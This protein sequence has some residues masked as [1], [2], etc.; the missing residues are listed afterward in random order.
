MTLFVAAPTIIFAIAAESALYVATETNIIESHKS[1]AVSVVNLATK[2]LANPVYFLDVDRINTIIQ[3]VKLNPDFKSVY[4]LRPDGRV[5]ADGTSENEMYGQ[6][7]DDAFTQRALAAEGPLVEIENKVM[8]VSAPIAVE[9]VQTL[10]IVRAQVSLD[11]LDRALGSLVATMV[12]TGVVISTAIVAIQI[13]LVRT[14]TRPIARL[15]STVKEIA[16]G[17]FDVPVESGR[18]D[19]I[20]ELF[21]NVDRMKKDLKERDRAQAEFVSIASHELRTPI[22]PILWFAKLARQNKIDR[23][24]AFEGIS[25][26]A[27]RL[28]KIANDILDVSRI[29][30]GDLK[31][32]MG[33]VRVN[34]I[35]A[36]AIGRFKVTAGTSVSL[37]VD[38]G[39]DVEIDGDESR[40]TQ[41]IDNAIA[42]AIKFT[43]EGT[44]KLETRAFPDKNR[45]IIRVTDTGE[46]ISPDIL[47]HLFDKFVTKDAAKDSHG[48]GLGLF[49][50][51]AIV[52]AHKGEI[53]AYNNTGRGATIEI[54]L[55]IDATLPMAA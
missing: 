46:G 30:S 33:K 2:E 49:I 15:G 53:T 7:L 32:V 3:N 22:Q 50:S 4:I 45:L 5:I 13:F 39:D 19:E 38:L 20:G 24:K 1:E 10:G 43:K 40:I 44:I 6:K 48:M 28:Q 37:E 26:H 27:E 25:Q 35:A 23:V 14:V 8:H 36:G 9:G 16:K 41:V 18:R 12:I 31:Y 47:P 54:A 17:K 55:P 34:D 29:E 51:K 42:N 11:E 21:S 52:L